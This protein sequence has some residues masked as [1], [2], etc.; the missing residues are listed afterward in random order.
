MQQSDSSI[1]PS[2]A[3]TCSFAGEKLMPAEHTP[4]GSSSRQ[5]L[6]GPPLEVA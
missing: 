6:R 3:P 4:A 1:V 5:A 2:D